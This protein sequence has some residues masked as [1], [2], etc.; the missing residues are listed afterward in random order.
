MSWI[1]EFNKRQDSQVRD[2]SWNKFQMDNLRAQQQAALAKQPKKKGFWTDQI[3]TGTGMGGAALGG[4]I[5]SAAGPIGTL[6]GA[7]LGGA[8]GSGGGE[9]AE[10]AMTGDDLMK[11]V[12]TEAAL[13]GV[14]SAGPLRALGAGKALLT[15]AGK[16][17]V[18]KAI[19]ATPIR[20]ALS[21]VLGKASDNAAIRGLGLNGSRIGKV[22]GK[23]IN[24]QTMPQ[25][26]KQEGLAGASVDDIASRIG[27]LNDEFGNI[28]A[29]TGTIPKST[30][31]KAVAA[32]N[33]AMNA[34][35]KMRGD[36]LDAKAVQDELEFALSKF[37][38]NIPAKELNALKARF[39]EAVSAASF[40]ADPAAKSVPNQASNLLRD[41]LRDQSVVAGVA[42]P[43]QLKAIGG[44]LSALHT[45]QD[46]AIK[47]ARTG[48][49]VGP[50]GMRDV[51]MGAGGS[52]A[53]GPVGAVATMGATHA[54]N[55]RG[56]Q[57]LLA[58]GADGLAGRVAA[59][60]PS[61]ITPLNS[62]LRAGA[63][64][65]M[66]QSLGQDQAQEDPQASL[67]ALNALGAAPDALD[68]M[69]QQQQTNPFGV[70][71]QEIGMAL[72]N[73]LAAGDKQ[74]AS[75]LKQMYDLAKESEGGAQ[76]LSGTTA[77]SLAMSSNGINT[78]D[79][80]E[81]LYGG[82][83]GGSGKLGGFVKS[84]LGKAGMD[85]NTATYEALAE[86]SVSQLAKAINGGG[87]VS[88]ADAAVII[89]ALPRVTDSPQVAR[90]KFAALKE[91]LVKARDNTL[92]YSSNSGAD[93]AQGSL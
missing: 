11:N 57:R 36:A 72:M 54:I 68:P 38:D 47:Q 27:Q 34:A 75:Q 71:S 3:S 56:A 86:S 9:M 20:N 41:V 33:K 22:E 8:L 26:L 6:L 29:N 52:I 73:A 88:D 18:E 70:S 84:Q 25:F 7:A 51:V 19:V 2:M 50:L 15:G 63:G 93:A 53:G 46:E 65:S 62:A 42:Q 32:N 37:G 87:Q 30:I 90:R 92:M 44:K 89:K 80:L 35:G 24:G 61:N 31:T 17:G 55:S 69:A 23:L 85:D 16:A 60:G 28:V 58:K 77:Q 4:L 48:K 13:G 1:D 10:N 21:G 76:K 5:G 45:L 67:D 81:R 43:G 79:Q 39:D 82:A 12:G 91:R 83:G 40:A 59:G 49:G 66:A 64:L 78:L 74:A 14:F